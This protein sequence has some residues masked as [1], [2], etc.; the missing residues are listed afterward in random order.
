MKKKKLKLQLQP[1]LK[2]S[3]LLQRQVLRPVRLTHL[4]PLLK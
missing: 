3:L 1:Q 2:L 4:H